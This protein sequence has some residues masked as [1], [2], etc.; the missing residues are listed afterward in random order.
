MFDATKTELKIGDK[1]LVL[2]YDGSKVEGVVEKLR[3]YIQVCCMTD[4]GTFRQ[5]F[6]SED[7]ARCITVLPRRNPVMPIETKGVS[8]SKNKFEFNIT[9][10]MI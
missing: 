6:S 10:S 9:R 4:E 1:V 3:P 8:I 2:Q 5:I 7:A